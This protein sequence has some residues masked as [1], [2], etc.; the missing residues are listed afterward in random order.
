[1]STRPWSS[2]ATVKFLGCA[3]PWAFL[4]IGTQS[5]HSHSCSCPKRPKTL[6]IAIVAPPQQWLAP[7]PGLDACSAAS[8]AF[9]CF[10][11]PQTLVKLCALPAN[12]YRRSICV[13]SHSVLYTHQ[14]G[15]HLFWKTYLRKSTTLESG[16]KCTPVL[17]SMAPY[18]LR[19]SRVASSG[20]PYTCASSG[21]SP[22]CYP[23]TSLFSRFFIMMR[24]S[25]KVSLSWPGL[26]LCSNSSDSAGS[27]PRH[28][29]IV[30]KC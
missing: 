2:H 19:S 18:L 21:A 1:M 13:Y 29:R 6:K 23:S 24:N 28:L 26:K 12:S 14:W 20:A 22:S 5:P 30:F 4:R 10:L 3:S 7:V 16:K 27:L 17:G 15:Q 8:G 9:L 25:A 11:G